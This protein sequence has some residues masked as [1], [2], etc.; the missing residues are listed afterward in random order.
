[1]IRP[2]VSA[3]GAVMG[4]AHLQLRHGFNTVLWLSVATIVVGTILYFVL[5]PSDRMVR[6]AQRVEFISPKAIIE[7]SWLV[8]GKFSRLWTKF[9]QNGYLRNY[10]STILVFLIVL[11]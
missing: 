9:F 4:D 1:L 11:S 5:T 7:K 3:M 8:F 6:S 10:I 2:D